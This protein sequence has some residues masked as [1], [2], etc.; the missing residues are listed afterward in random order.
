MNM[1]LKNDIKKYRAKKSQNSKKAN[2]LLRRLKERDEAS[3]FEK[4]YLKEAY[5]TSIMSECTF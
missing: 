5:Q 3:K 2:R 1:L 4:S